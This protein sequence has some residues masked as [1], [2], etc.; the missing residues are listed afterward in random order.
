[1]VND[2]MVSPTAHST[3]QCTWKP[4]EL[5]AVRQTLFIGKRKLHTKQETSKNESPEGKPGPSPK[6]S[7][8]LLQS[9]GSKIA[10][11]SVTWNHEWKTNDTWSDKNR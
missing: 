9:R 7:Q 8:N 6:Q 11:Y 1:M 10:N 4:R 3:N 5:A 2:D